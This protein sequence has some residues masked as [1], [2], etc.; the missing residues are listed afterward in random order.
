[1]SCRLTKLQ[2]HPP[3][4]SSTPTYN[5][6]VNYKPTLLPRLLPPPLATP[7][8]QSNR[9]YHDPPRRSRRQFHP[10]ALLIHPPNLTSTPNQPPSTLN[11][12]LARSSRRIRRQMDPG[13]WPACPTKPRSLTITRPQHQQNLPFRLPRHPITLLQRTPP[14][15]QPTDRNHRDAARR[16]RDHR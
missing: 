16:F 8:P 3:T 4:P 15:P 9:I 11:H 13:A 12:N 1:M 2:L 14:R 10:R 6:N 5:K 7:I